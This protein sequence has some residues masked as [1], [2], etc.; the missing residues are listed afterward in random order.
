[1]ISNISNPQMMRFNI[2]DEFPDWHE[3]MSKSRLVDLPYVD[4]VKTGPGPVILNSDVTHCSP[5]YG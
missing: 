4:L 1:M 5:K 3:I 2:Q